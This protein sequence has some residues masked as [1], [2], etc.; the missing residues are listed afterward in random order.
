MYSILSAIAGILG[1]GLVVVWYG[2]DNNSS[3][4]TPGRRYPTSLFYAT[5]GFA[6]QLVL[7]VFLLII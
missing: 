5:M 7:L 4:G 2:R 6:I 3:K 1:M